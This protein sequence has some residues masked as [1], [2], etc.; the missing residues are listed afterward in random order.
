MFDINNLV[1]GRVIPP[2]PAT[3]TY[4][5]NSN[6][7]SGSAYDK[8]VRYLREGANGSRCEFLDKNGRNLG[9]VAQRDFKTAKVP[10]GT[11]SLK[12]WD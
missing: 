4:D 7:T 8:A 6:G 9:V 2:T 11:V 5:F 10:K 12:V 3:T 1:T